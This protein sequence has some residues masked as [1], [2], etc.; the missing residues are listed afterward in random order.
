MDKIN[1]NA[2]REGKSVAQAM[3]LASDIH[4]LETGEAM[5][6]LINGR[7]F[8][9]EAARTAEPEDTPREAEG[10]SH[11]KPSDPHLQRLI[12]AAEKYFDLENEPYSP[13][14]PPDV[15]HREQADAMGELR[16]A[17]KALQPYRSGT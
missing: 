7:R 4:R 8:R 17:T 15:I 14:R 5:T 16:A 3:K 10:R 2:R 13:K 9:I 6:V 1:I 12:E 11:H